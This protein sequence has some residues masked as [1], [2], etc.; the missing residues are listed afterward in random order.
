MW[1]LAEIDSVSASG[2]EERGRILDVQ[3]PV[4][5][6]SRSQTHPCIVYQNVWKIIR[7]SVNSVAAVMK[8]GSSYEG[9]VICPSS[10]LFSIPFCLQ[11]ALGTLHQRR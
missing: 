9:T 3:F 7:T 8:A 5:S 6:Q 11:L 10:A 2:A 1:T 4:P